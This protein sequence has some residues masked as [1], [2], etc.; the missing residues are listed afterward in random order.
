MTAIFFA[1]L[2]GNRSGNTELSAFDRESRFY[3]L[4]AVWIALCHNM[5]LKNF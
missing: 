5:L 3:P 1:L 4:C 2:L